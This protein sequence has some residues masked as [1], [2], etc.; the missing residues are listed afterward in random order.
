[1]LFNHLIIVKT[2]SILALSLI[3]LSS[4]NSNKDQKEQQELFPVTAAIKIDTSS[5]TEYVSEIHA[6]QNVEI[7]ARVK[8]YLEKFHID[9]G[10]YVKEGQLLFTINN[11]EIYARVL[12]RHKKK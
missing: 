11:K 5:Y 3:I 4:C 8:G 6:L 10:M 9:E 12:I 2:L 1:M 7:R